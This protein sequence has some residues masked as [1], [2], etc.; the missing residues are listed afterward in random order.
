MV[1][2]LGKYSGE[3]ETNNRQCLS[4]IKHHVSTL[5]KLFYSI[6]KSFLVG[7][8]VGVFHKYWE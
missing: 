7:I 8:T 3:E 4:C 1:I 6:F 2:A 5:C